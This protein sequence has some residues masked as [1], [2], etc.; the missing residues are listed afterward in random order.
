MTIMAVAACGL[1]PIATDEMDTPAAPRAVPTIP[2]MPGRSSLRTM[3][4]C[5]EGATTTT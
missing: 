4:M 1:G 5:V 2:I 3:S